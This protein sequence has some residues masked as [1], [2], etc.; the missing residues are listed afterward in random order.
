MKAAAVG[1]TGMPTTLA[2]MLVVAS[3]I[4]SSTASASSQKEKEIAKEETEQG[5]EN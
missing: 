2:K 1:T 4:V 5:R 3:S